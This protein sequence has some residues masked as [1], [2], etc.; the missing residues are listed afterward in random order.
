MEFLRR[1]ECLGSMRVL[2]CEKHRDR[3]EKERYEKL[4]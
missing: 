2:K 3:E 4:A 1:M